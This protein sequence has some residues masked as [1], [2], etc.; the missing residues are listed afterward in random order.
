[1]IENKEPLGCINYSQGYDRCE[2]QCEKC[3]QLEN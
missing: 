3:K 2:I 1:M